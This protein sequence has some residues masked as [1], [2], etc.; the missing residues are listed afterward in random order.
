[1][2]LLHEVGT[3]LIVMVIIVAVLRPTAFRYLLDKDSAEPSLGRIGQFIALM[4]STW[5]FVTLVL[6]KDLNEWFFIGYMGVWAGAQATSL[7]LKIKG[8]AGATT[9]ETS[10]TSSSSTKVTP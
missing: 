8:Q 4:T 6:M 2:T 10:S 3:A 9:T 7:F 5:V 1:V